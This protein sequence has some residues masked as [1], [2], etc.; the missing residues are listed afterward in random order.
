MCEY[1]LSIPNTQYACLY[2]YMYFRKVYCSITI[3]VYIHAVPRNLY[4]YASIMGKCGK[5]SLGYVLCNQTK[6]FCVQYIVLVCI[7]LIV[8]D[9]IR[10]SFSIKTMLV[11][12]ILDL[13]SMILEI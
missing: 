11:F 3:S 6:I 13:I 8:L 10:T 7:I 9:H 1:T 4:M 2:M 5:G 12:H